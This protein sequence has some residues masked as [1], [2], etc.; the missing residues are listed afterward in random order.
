MTCKIS[1]KIKSGN[2]REV[3]LVSRILYLLSDVTGVF[4]GKTTK[5]TD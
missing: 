2:K 3:V 1:A 5:N 4:Y